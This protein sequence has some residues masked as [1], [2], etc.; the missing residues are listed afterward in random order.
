MVELAIVLTI[1]GILIVAVISAQSLV[2]QA[3]SKDVIAIIGDLR[4]ATTYFKQRYKYLPGDWPYTASEIPNVTAATT[5]GINGNGLV[6]GA[7]AADG[8]AEADS[9]VAV[10]PLQLYGAGFLGK[11]DNSEP[12][13]RIATSFGPVQVVSK[14][15]ANGLVAGFSAANPTASNAIVFFKL[16]CELVAEVDA[17]IDD[18]NPTNGRALGTAC[19]N[20]IVLWYAV[21]L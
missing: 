14:G 5:V 4:N 7:I 21:V 8:K 19:V 20:N 6:E 10:L 12:L 2:G 1:V 17:K 15:T 18:A 16:P 9:E 13:S 11:I 3:K